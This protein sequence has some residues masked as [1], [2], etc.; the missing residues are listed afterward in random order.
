MRSDLRLIGALV[1]TVLIV[2]FTLQNTDAV[3]VRFFLWTLATSR[4]LLI[5]VV[6]AIGIV[7]GWLLRSL[8]SR[9]SQGRSTPT[10][11]GDNADA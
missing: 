5:F 1:I 6:L 8:K 4:A 3:L 9:K 10:W 7:L 2:I 11:K